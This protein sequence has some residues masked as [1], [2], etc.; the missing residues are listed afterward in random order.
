MTSLRRA[1]ALRPPAPGQRG[2]IT[3]F[4][5]DSA[6]LVDPNPLGDPVTR[7]VLVYL[8][9]GYQD[10]DR[11]RYPALWSLPAYTSSGPAQVAW[12]NH[13]ENLPQRLDRLIASGAMPPAI[14]A[15]PD[16]FTALGGNQFVDSPALGNYARHLI[17]ELVPELDRRF[18]TI[19]RPA[20]RGVFGKSSG[21]FGALH[22][23]AQHPGV[24]GGIASHA[25]DC[26][27]DRVYQRDFVVCCDELALFEGDC[28][29]FVSAFWRAR[30]P[31]GRAFHA[32]MVLCLAASYSPAPGEPLNLELPFSLETARLNDQVWQRWLNFDPVRFDDRQFDALRQLRALW[33]DVGNRDQY[34]IHYGTR[35]L[36]ARLTAAGV[37]HRFETFDGN[38]SGMDWR[39]DHSLPWLLARLETVGS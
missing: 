33:I 35:E 7:D 28:E 34:F 37:A 31:S 6:L 2:T 39:L 30:K 14:V 12:R 24:F 21:G 10:E 1:T 15:M 36:A 32:L 9:P 29:A 4:R 8:P 17:E 19:A 23:A 18:R 22:L 26:G 5:H 25:G 11:R 20:A 27:F 13:G 38:H 16:S 3:S